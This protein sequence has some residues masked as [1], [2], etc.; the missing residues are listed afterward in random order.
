MAT[1]L[2]DRS[3]ALFLTRP[4]NEQREILDGWNRSDRKS[5][6]ESVR[7]MVQ[8]VLDMVIDAESYRY[9][10]AYAEATRR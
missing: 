1:T 3:A 4:P 7:S 6:V 2:D 10:R 8:R 9:V 5:L